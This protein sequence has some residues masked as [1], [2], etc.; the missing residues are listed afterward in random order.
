MTMPLNTPFPSAP[1]P[2]RRSLQAA[3]LAC[4]LAAAPMAAS[5]QS[6]SRSGGDFIV[7]VVN[8]ELV[9]NTE[10]QQR[11][12]QA[13]QD[14]ER[15]KLRLPARDDLVQ[16]ILD[17]LIDERAQLSYARETGVKVDEAEV[18]RAWSSIAAQNQLTATQLRERLRAEGMDPTRFR[19]N[20][21]DQIALDRVRDREVQ[22]RVRILDA[23]IETWL[24]KERERRGSA[25]EFNV[26][27]ILYAVPEGAPPEKWAEQR[28][29]ALQALQRLNQGADFATLVQ[30]ESDG[31]RERAGALGLKRIDKLP[32][33]FAEAV[34]PLR[35][36]EIAPQIVRSGAGYHLL[37]VLDRQ[38]A[39]LTITQRH[40]RHILMRPTPGQ[41][42][43]ATVKRLQ[44]FKKRIAS[45]SVRFEELARRHSE[46]GSAAGGGDLG[47]ANP[48]QFVPEFERVLESLQPN[49][50]SD[51]VV[52][53]FGVHLI[54]LIETREMQLSPADQREMARNALREQK[55]EETYNEWARDIRARAYIELREPPSR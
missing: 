25:T 33:A 45:G 35:P 9:T 52:S 36:G 22:S 30:Q 23:D 8:Q 4:V 55:R 6:A 19:A 15:R 47:W 5:A 49:Q 10:V 42:E 26:A 38:D 17:R 18:E 50:V 37:K 24:S 39:A 44:D 32:D 51:P 40:A 13:E 2:L 46:D 7:A 1:S 14:A 3:V 29:R 20:L 27:Q 28:A 34:R 48:G 31:P 12:E 53:R 43:Q 41:D 11:I 54:Q 21:R 16:M